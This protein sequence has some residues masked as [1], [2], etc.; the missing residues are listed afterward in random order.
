MGAV[1]IAM[2]TWCLKSLRTCQYAT[3]LLMHLLTHCELARFAA[4]SVSMRLL[5]IFT[6]ET[7]PQ[8]FDGADQFVEAVRVVAL[9]VGV[10]PVIEF[11]YELGRYGPALVRHGLQQRIDR[12]V[13]LA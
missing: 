7:S 6:K 1:P 3:R 13:R 2:R 5:Q 11:G 12:G 10:E 8:R 4:Q 9:R